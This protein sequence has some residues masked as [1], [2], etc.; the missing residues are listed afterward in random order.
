MVTP[1]CGRVGPFDIGTDYPR[2]GDGKP[3]HDGVAS[4]VESRVIEVP[5]GSPDDGPDVQ[6]VRTLRGQD[7]KTAVVSS[8]NNC[9]AVLA[10]ARR[11]GVEASRVV[12]VED[13]LAGVKAGHAG[14][15]G[16]VI[17]VDSLGQ[18]R[19]LRD[20]GVCL[21]VRTNQSNMHVAQMVRTRA[22][23]WMESS[24]TCRAGRSARPGIS[25]RNSMSRSNKVRRCFL[26]NEWLSIRHATTRF[27][28]AHW[29]RARQST[30]QGGLIS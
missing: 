27:R 25:D 13:A 19:A 12:V 7:I 17:G 20:G 11:P 21:L 9:A 22:C 14:R 15:F 6:R 2:Y 28:N 26:K 23:W 16:R 1:P 29:R 24:L 18:A 10:A 3:R 5:M 30:A 4:F 8:S